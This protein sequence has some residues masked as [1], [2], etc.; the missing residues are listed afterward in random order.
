MLD[1]SAARKVVTGLGVAKVSA[2]WLKDG[3]EAGDEHV[4][5]DASQQR[6]VD[7]S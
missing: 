7:P 5:R 6:L 3:L 2:L 4:G 1:V